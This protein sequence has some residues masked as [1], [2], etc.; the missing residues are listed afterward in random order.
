MKAVKSF[1]AA[2]RACVRVGVDVCMWLSV[3]VV[4]WQICVMSPWLFNARM[5]CVRRAVNARVLERGLNAR[6]L[7][8]LLNARVL[9][10][11]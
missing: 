10:E 9:G 5:I 7:G 6:V 4:L 2:S 8:R 11:G 1:D 3:I